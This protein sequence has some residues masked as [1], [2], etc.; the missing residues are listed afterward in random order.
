MKKRKIAVFTG[1]RAEYG[2]MRGVVERLAADERVELHL[3]V[4]G[5]HLSERYGHTMDEILHDG[6]APIHEADIDLED[7]TPAGV[8][9]SMGKGLAIYGR[10]LADLEPHLLMALGDRYESFCAVT[11]ATLLQ[12]PIAHLYGGAVTEGAVDDVL[13]HAM[14]K[15]S[16]LHFTSCER[17]RNRIIQ[18]GENPARVWCVG[19]TGAENVR[20]LP[21]LP[22]EEVRRY[23]G[24]PESVSYVV[25]TY[26]PVT[27]EKGEAAEEAEMLLE[28]LSARRDL[29][30][31][32]TG[33]N[34]DTGGNAVNERL[35]LRT[36][37]DPRL[38][39]F[40]SLGTERYIQAVRYSVGVVGNSSSGVGEVPSL[41]VPVLDIGDR[42]KGRER[43]SGV[44]HCPLEPQALAE[45]LDI[46]L[47]PS[48]RERAR[49]ARN[50]LEKNGS[51]LKIAQTVSTFPLDGI[52][53]KHF[54]EP[55][56]I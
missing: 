5:S 45:A 32:F 17:Y 22:E 15:M 30:Y 21:A 12:I 54:Y 25:V 31:V 48:F 8:C 53:K 10:L 20:R 51:S 19:S 3:V 35:K 41:G 44:L 24:L 43:S 7:N 47:S 11:A 34:A 16:H 49:Q 6:F 36:E 33:A 28:A 29:M 4:S 39:F 2:L 40:L 50:P 46:L 26:H 1:S 38:R 37:K 13:R 9:R 42:Q 27:L 18:M 14:T 56:H 55:E 52:L 23:L